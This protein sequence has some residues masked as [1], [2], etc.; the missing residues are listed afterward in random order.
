M[1]SFLRSSMAAAV[2]ASMMSCT[3][4]HN[5]THNEDGTLDEQKLFALG[6]RGANSAR[7]TAWD[8]QKNFGQAMAAGT[9]IGLGVAGAMA[10]KATE[11]T[12]QAAA[13]YA[14]KTQQTKI[15]TEGAVKQSQIGANAGAFNAAVQGGA[16]PTVGTVVAPPP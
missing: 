6:G 9:A 4:V 10:T 1:R 8:N 16:V 3:A 5:K 7:G 14:A 11:G 2:M 13:G 15:V 12:K